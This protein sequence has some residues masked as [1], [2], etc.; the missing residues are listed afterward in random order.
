MTMKDENTS[1]YSKV[2]RL[3][4]GQW[5]RCCP[6]CLGTKVVPRPSILGIVEKADWICRDCGFTGITIE[7]LVEDIKKIQSG[8]R[9]PAPSK[10]EEKQKDT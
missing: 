3:Q 6:V 9:A 10:D 5:V 7:A 2:K 8:R 1:S 4:K